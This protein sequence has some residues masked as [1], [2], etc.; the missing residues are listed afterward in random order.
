MKFKTETVY[1]TNANGFETMRKEVINRASVNDAIMT[2]ISEGL[3]G[4]T[5]E[6][7]N[8]ARVDIKAF[9]ADVRKQSVKGFNT[10]KGIELKNASK[11]MLSAI[12]FEIDNKKTA[13]SFAK[14]SKRPDA[15]QEFKQLLSELQTLESYL[16]QLS[17]L[18]GFTFNYDFEFLN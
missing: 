12:L 17:D 18:T 3:K 8:L 10:Q 4:N 2:N 7:I 13:L 14:M 1:Q 6:T 9:I 15:G 11:Q 5:P 16:Q